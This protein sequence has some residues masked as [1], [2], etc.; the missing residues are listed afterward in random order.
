[1]ASARLRLVCMR[2]GLSQAGQPPAAQPHMVLA[3][4]VSPE[5]GP[6]ILDNLHAEVLPASARPDLSPVFGCG[7]GCL[8]HGNGPARAGDP[9]QRLSRWRAVWA[10][11]RAEGFV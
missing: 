6:L 8:W 2:A 5:D 3:Y 4:Q 9:L 10:K 1:M 11:M 7:T